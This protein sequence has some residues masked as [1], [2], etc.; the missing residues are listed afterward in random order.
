[1]N[2]C[3]GLENMVKRIVIEV[4]MISSF[5]CCAAAAKSIVQTPGNPIRNAGFFVC[6]EQL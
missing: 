2:K 1:M 6:G 4:G 3:D 5:V